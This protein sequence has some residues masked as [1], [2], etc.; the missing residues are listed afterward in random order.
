MVDDFGDDCFLL[1]GK[2]PPTVLCGLRE[3]FIMVPFHSTLQALES[4]VVPN[5][6]HG[7]LLPHS[8]LQV[9]SEQPPL[10]GLGG[11]ALCFQLGSDMEV[12]QPVPRPSSEVAGFHDGRMVPMATRRGKVLH[13]SMWDCA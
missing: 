11:L 5:G 13:V 7:I 10:C 4:E 8:I 6:H 9:E 2:T 12:T 1:P 3:P